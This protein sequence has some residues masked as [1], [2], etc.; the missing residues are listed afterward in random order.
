MKPRADLDLHAPIPLSER[1]VGASD[2]VIWSG[3]ASAADVLHYA[4]GDDEVTPEA[5]RDTAE[6]LRGVPIVSA[7]DHQRWLE[8]QT[9]GRDYTLTPL[10]TVLD[11]ALDD[12]GRVVFSASVHD[13]RANA[14]MRTRT[15]AVSVGYIAR[16]GRSSRADRA[17][18]G[19]T[20]NHLALVPRG[21]DPQA[22]IRADGVSMPTLAELPAEDAV[23]MIVAALIAATK[24][25]MEP[26]ID[27][28]LAKRMDAAA[29]PAPPSDSAAVSAED[30]A[31]MKMESEAA[32][33]DA[34][35]QKSRADAAEARLLDH[36][37]ARVRADA[38]VVG[39]T[40]TD[41]DLKDAVSV[42]AATEKVNAAALAKVRADSLN[43]WK[44]GEARPRVDGAASPAPSF[45]IN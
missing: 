12:E 30:M 21:R 14:D 26:L 16:Y 15:P 6:Q 9:A 27:G 28:L 23:K 22:R 1:G 40:F 45:K 17:Q 35:A 37:R 39:L 7:E 31:K 13:R 20:V 2:S 42:R 29:D 24:T 5:R 33:A 32:K 43:P 38:A 41:A 11:S 34:A 44:P 8:A 36:E 10:G 3:V 19:R 4:D 25:E 18:T